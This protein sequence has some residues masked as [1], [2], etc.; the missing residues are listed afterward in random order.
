VSSL[1]GP[2][3]DDPDETG[4]TEQSEDTLEPDADGRRRDRRLLRW[5]V[6]SVVVVVAALYLAGYA[7]AGDRLPQDTTIAG[8]DVGGS[9]PDDARR[10]LADA[11]RSRLDDPVELAVAG[12]IFP[13]DPEDAGLDVDVAASVAQVPVG[14]S[15]NPADMW[16]TVVGGGEYDAVVVTIDDLLTRRL[17]EVAGKVE[18]PAVEG[19]V[20]F[21]RDGAEP[22]YPE[23]GRVLDVAAA[24]A[25][26]TAAYP[27]DGEPVEVERVAAEPGVSSDEVSRA[28]KEF[29]NPAMAAPVTY[30]VGGEPVV[31]RPA[32]FARALSMR[33]E[34]GELVP[35][36]DTKALRKVF[37]PEMRTVGQQPR[38]ATVRIVD[39]EPRI[40]PAKKGVTVDWE[41]VERSFLRLVAAEE[42]KRELELPTTV[43]EPDRTTEEVR[44]LGIVEEVSEF[45]TYYPHADYR[46]VNIGR[47]AE[48]ID[49]TLLEPGDMFSLNEIV[50]ERT[51]ENGFARGTIIS[52]GVFKEDYGGGVS[53]VATT[54][55]NA[56]FFAGLEDVE[57]KP[58]SVYIDR[59]PVGREATVAWPVVDL[60][61][62]N[63]TDH[64]VLIETEHTPSSW[65]NQGSV[66]VRMWST[67]VWD[68]ESITGERYAFTSP[69]TRVMSGDD[70]IPNEGYG[71]FQ[72]D[73]TRVFRRA[74][75]SGVV[76]R[77]VM[78]TTYIPSDTVV[79]R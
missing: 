75:E 70:C 28:M 27:S 59:Y 38:D 60:R 29:A 55:F 25:A 21:T 67:K 23:D 76:R 9:R 65:A 39:G 7:F 43:E 49:G 52:N 42:G 71:G 44:D 62:R 20:R 50:G 53:Q 66:T 48:L 32:R 19:G 46:N 69:Q 34:D 13:I 37:R 54:T 47:A 45:T 24:E 4:E 35:E 33:A 17:E 57:H 15:W 5:L 36:V 12:R 51:A 74:G 30:T 6:V 10:E 26:V 2:G 18:E 8:V 41:R 61:F 31:L 63:D 14:R 58:H 72:I 40:V 3:R 77:E 68:I 79:C 16:E 78:H 1:F 11:L 73:V 64:G 22:T 56:A